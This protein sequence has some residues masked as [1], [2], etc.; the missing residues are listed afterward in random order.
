MRRNP[1]HVD[2]QAQ[3]PRDASPP[4]LNDMTTAAIS[5]PRPV[6]SLA[7]TARLVAAALTVVAATSVTPAIGHVL[8]SLAPTASFPV[9]PFGGSGPVR[10]A[11][12]GRIEVDLQLANSSRLRRL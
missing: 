11:R 9:T 8:A 5:T 12:I 1:H 2:G 4:T 6:R 7:V 10:I 3:S